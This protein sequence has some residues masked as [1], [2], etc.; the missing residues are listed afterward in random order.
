MIVGYT[1]AYATTNALA[2]LLDAAKVVQNTNII[3]ILIGSGLEKERLIEKKEKLRLQN[4][5]FF[6]PIPK[7]SIPRLL[8]YFDIFI[9]RFTEPFSFSVLVLA[10]IK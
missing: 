3:F 4:V 8:S 2:F 6:D 9:H 5:Y 1:G 7:S 10:P